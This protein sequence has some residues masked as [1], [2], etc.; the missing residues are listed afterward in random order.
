ML[1][2]GPRSRGQ[3]VLGDQLHI[4]D[5]LANHPAHNCTHLLNRIQITD[6]VPPRE[7]VRISAQMLLTELVVHPFVR[8][9]EGRP[10]RFHAVRVRF[11]P[12]KLQGGVVHRRVLARQS[13]VRGAFIGKNLRSCARV[14]GDKPLERFLRRVRHRFHRNRV[15][16]AVFY[17]HYRGLARR[18]SPCVLLGIMVLI[19]LFPAKICFVHLYRTRK[20]VIRTGLKRLAKALQQEPG[21]FLTDPQFPM[22]SHTRHAFQVGGEQVDADC[23][24]AVTDLRALHDRPRLHAKQGTLVTFTATVVHC[25]MFDIPLDVVRPA[26][27]TSGRSAPALLRKPRLGIVIVSE[28]VRN[29]QI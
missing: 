5:A 21:S 10:E 17:P 22:Q 13:A 24:A 2:C 11:A 29:F 6:I 3:S 1:G 14:V 12:H 18:A 16:R 28:L 23:P 8:T 25:G 20:R 7:L 15:R 26:V 4:A 27:G 19:S 9:L